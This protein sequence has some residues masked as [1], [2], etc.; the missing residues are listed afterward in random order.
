MVPGTEGASSSLIIDNPGLDY[1]SPP[2]VTMGDKG[3]DIVPKV[4]KIK[5]AS[6]SGDPSESNN[7]IAS[8]KKRQIIIHKRTM[9]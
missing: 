5:T 9:K 6:G 3:S 4:T 2:K 7:T 8:E 1:S